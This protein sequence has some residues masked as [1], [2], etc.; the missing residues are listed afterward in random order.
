VRREPVH[1]LPLRQMPD[2]EHEPG[3]QLYQRW[4]EPTCWACQ[5]GLCWQS[6]TAYFR[7]GEPA[8]VVHGTRAAS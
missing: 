4:N 5:Q 7:D 2:I 3:A 8:V 6:V 1:V